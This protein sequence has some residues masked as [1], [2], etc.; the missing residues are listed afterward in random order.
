MARAM[1]WIPLV[2]RTTF[3]AGLALGAW[4]LAHVAF[5]VAGVPAP[6]AVAWVVLLV[7]TSAAVSYSPDAIRGT[8][9]LLGGSATPTIRREGNGFVWQPANAPV[10]YVYGGIGIHHAWLDADAGKRVVARVELEIPD[11][12]PPAV[13]RS[14]TRDGLRGATRALPG[15]GKVRA[16]GA[17]E[18]V[19]GPTSLVRIHLDVR[20]P[21]ADRE[22]ARAAAHG[23]GEAFARALGKSGYGARP[24]LEGPR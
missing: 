23:F 7:V 11:S 15:R 12:V 13:L 17:L 6:L 9:P 18:D 1:A 16:R 24:T 2:A 19:P 21:G 3:F 4:W 20:G 10:P 14:A 8:L 5:G 22:W